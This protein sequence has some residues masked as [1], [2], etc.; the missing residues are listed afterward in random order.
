[1]TH[2]GE[3]L[4]RLKPPHIKAFLSPLDLD[5]S[6]KLTMGRTCVAAVRNLPRMI[7]HLC[8]HHF[9]VHWILTC[10]L[11]STVGNRVIYKDTRA[12]ITN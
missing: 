1:M 7:Q 5:E 9:I 4:A 2:A 6:V 8:S 10:L 3:L 12:L 11:P